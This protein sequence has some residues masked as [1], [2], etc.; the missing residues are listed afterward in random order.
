M[1]IIGV[2]KEIKNNENR[3]AL[4]PSGAMELIRRGHEVYIQST[5]GVNSGF[6]DEDYI[7]QGAKILPTIEE[8]YAIAEMIVKVKEPIEPEYKL[9]KRDQLVFTYFHFASSEP[10]T[11]AMIDSGA[12]CCQD[13]LYDTLYPI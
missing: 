4:T 9:I 8:V 12:I 7:E 6:K 5:A 10:L 3:V 2:P 13:R 11:K 1:M